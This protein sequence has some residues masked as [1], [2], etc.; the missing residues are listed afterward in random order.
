MKFQIINRWSGKVIVEAEA[1][2]L[3]EVVVSNKSDLQ[4]ADLQGADLQGADLQE[5]NLREANLRG[6]NLPDN[7]KEITFR[8]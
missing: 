5:A 1:E 8:D 7:W 3:S 4:G 6:A 2:T